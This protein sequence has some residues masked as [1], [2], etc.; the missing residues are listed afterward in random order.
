LR[1]G[2]LVDTGSGTVRE[3]G[4]ALTKPVIGYELVALG[5]EPMAPLGG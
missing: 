4:H 2:E 5:D 1:D 3:V